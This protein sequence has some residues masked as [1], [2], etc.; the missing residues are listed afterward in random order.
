MAIV[1]VYDALR[2]ARPYK[3][4]LSHE[5]AVTVLLQ[6]TEAGYWEPQLISTFIRMFR[7]LGHANVP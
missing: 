4:P 3:A 7:D 6:E 5:E 1:D 2:T